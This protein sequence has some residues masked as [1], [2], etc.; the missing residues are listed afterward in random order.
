MRIGYPGQHLASLVTGVEG[1][2]TGA[3]GHDLSDKSEVKSC[4]RIDQLD[5]CQSCKAAVARIESNCPSCGSFSVDRRNDSK[6]LFSI[7]N[8]DELKYLLDIVPRVVLI[9]SDY[10]NFDQGDWSTI[11]FQVFEIW[12]DHPRHA[13]FRTLMTNY[14][15]RIYSRHIADNPSRTPAPKNFWPYSFQFYMCNPIR[16]FHCVIEDALENPSINTLEY[17]E[18]GIDRNGVMPVR[19]P[20][21]LLKPAERSKMSALFNGTELA[22]MAAVGLAESERN[23][24]SLRETD[25][26]APQNRSYTRGAR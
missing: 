16:T 8:E 26:A 1:A 22:A 15:C 19:M 5:K 2:R 18:P 20:Y 7:K 10:P 14:Y 12:P 23:C 13:N 25:F 4:S 17:V 9:I 11:Q 3:R 21:S 24:L 6:W